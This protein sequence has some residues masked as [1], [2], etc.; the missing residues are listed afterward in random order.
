MTL[1]EIK[2]AVDQGLTVHWASE[3]FQVINDRTGYLIQCKSNGHIIGL[4]WADGITMNGEEHQFFVAEEGQKFAR[5]CYMSGRPIN[6]G[7]VYKDGEKYFGSD[8]A[9]AA[10]LRSNNIDDD[11]EASDEFLVSESYTVGESYYTEW[12]DEDDMDYI[13]QNGVLIEI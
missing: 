13:V 5:M 2:K 6:E 4:T 9:L 1:Q 3:L 12:E 8:E 11:I 7:H 10:Y